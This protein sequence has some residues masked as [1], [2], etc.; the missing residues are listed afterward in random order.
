MSDQHLAL[1]HR[2][3]AKSCPAQ[4][5]QGR[6]KGPTLAVAVLPECWLYDACCLP[7]V[8]CQVADVFEQLATTVADST[9]ASIAQLMAQQ[10]E[11]SRQ[12]Q[13]STP[14]KSYCCC[15][16]PA[17]GRAVDMQINHASHVVLKGRLPK[18]CA[19]VCGRQVLYH[20]AMV[21]ICL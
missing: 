16:T 4:F 2:V 19:G 3:V 18:P 21:C 10:Q 14:C 12:G 5:A 20:P 7:A 15:T 8:A 13:A 11:V 1:A 9:Q 17:M 6:G